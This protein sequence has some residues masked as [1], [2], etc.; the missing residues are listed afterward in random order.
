MNART[1]HLTARGVRFVVG[2]AMFAGIASQPPATAA[3]AGDP[4][5]GCEQ[6]KAKSSGKYAQCIAGVNA[7]AIKDSATTADAEKLT[8]CSDKIGGAFT[9]AEEKAEGACRTDGD[10]ATI[11][12]VLDDC[13]NGVV[14]SLGGLPGP[15]GDAAKCQS[16]K[17]KESGKYAACRFKALAKGIK[18]GVAPDFTKCNDKLSNKWTKLEEKTCSTTGDG[19]TVKAAIDACYDVVAGNLHPTIEYQQ[20]FES[21]VQASS[22]ALSDDGWLVYGTVFGPDWSRWYG[23][24]AFPAPNG[25]PAFSGIDIGQ[26]GPEQGSQQMVVYSDYNNG[27]HGDG[28]NAHIESNVYHERT[29]VA[30]DVGR[31]LTF[32]ADA[33]RGNINDP[34]GSSTA[35]A[36]IKTL[37]PGNSWAMTHF[38]THDTTSLPATWTGLSIELDIDAT[39]VGQILQYG[40]STTASNYEPSANFYDNVVVSTVP[41][42]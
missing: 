36:F 10:T 7:K 37:D 30:G 26:G 6:G 38:I 21:L 42:P 29:I 2:A 11:K 18:D 41:T 40:F 23:Y 4:A 14:T 9:K 34:A 5:D 39:L 24:G 1:S 27:N 35:L 16:G 32:A 20:N 33:K 17:V 19:A 15:G 22:T 25:G 3:A 12:G 8:K 31:T 28:S 13:I